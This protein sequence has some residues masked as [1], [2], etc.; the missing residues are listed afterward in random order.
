LEA[1]V[2]NLTVFDRLLSPKTVLPLALGTALLVRR[3]KGAERLAIA[4]TLGIA[5]EEIMKRTVS[6]R[7]PGRHAL[8]RRQSFPSGHSAGSTAYL[9]SLALMAPAGWSRVAGLVFAAGAVVS[10]DVIR[11]REREHWISDV[12]AGDLVGAV[13]VSL[14]HGA[15]VL[16]RRSEGADRVTGSCHVAPESPPG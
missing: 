3:R 12:L 9:V 7:R 5:V 4:T 8:A 2:R 13:A 15:I 14:A 10:V 16:F 11:V 1:A 6:R